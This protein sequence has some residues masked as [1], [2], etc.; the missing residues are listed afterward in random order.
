MLREG[1][2]DAKL[3]Q[4]RKLGDAQAGTRRRGEGR[5]GRVPVAVPQP[6]DA[7]SRRPAPRGSSPTASW[8]CGRR[9]RTARPRWLAA[10]DAAG[11][12]LEK[13]EVHKMMLGGGFGRRG[14]TQ[15]FVRQGVAI[16]KAMPGMPVKLM[17]SREEDMQHGFYRPAS[18]VRMRAGL[19]AQGRVI[20]MHTRIACPSILAVLHRRARPAGTASTSPRCARFSDMPYAIAEPAGGLRDAQRP[21]AGGLLAR[22][23]PAERVLPRVLHRRAGAGGGQGP[24]SSSGWRC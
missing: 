20:A 14:A 8:R 21:R 19:D 2:A 11:L 15:D 18:I 24:A 6:R 5:R 1:L 22:A 23:G 17:W 10:A 12:P 3:P 9:R 13:V 16:A 7:W 4:A